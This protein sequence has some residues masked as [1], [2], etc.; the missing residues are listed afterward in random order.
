M[1]LFIYLLIIYQC[2]WRNVYWH[3]NW[4]R[5]ATFKF[6]P[7]L[8]RSLNTNDLRKS[9]FLHPPHN[10]THQ[11]N[12]NIDWTFQ[13]LWQLVQGKSYSEFKSIEKATN[14]L[15]KNIKLFLQLQPALN[16]IA[17]QT[18]HSSPRQQPI[19][20]NGYSELT[21]MEKETGIYSNLFL[22]KSQQFIDNKRKG[23]VESPDD[24]RH[25]TVASI[26]YCVYFVSSF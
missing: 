2:R 8:L 18:E 3:E 9:L 1:F 4:N 6:R 25:K 15:G 7:R 23:S 21:V 24:L 14:V 13:P 16:Q 12:S 17:G 22:N 20:E 11:L 26:I 5:R 10:H 19:E